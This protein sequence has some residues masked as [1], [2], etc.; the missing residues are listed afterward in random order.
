[1]NLAVTICQR[2]EQKHDHQEEAYGPE[3]LQRLAESGRMPRGK[4]KRRDQY[5]ESRDGDRKEHH[6]T[7]REDHRQLCPRI[8]HIE[9]PAAGDEGVRR[10]SPTSVS[11]TFP[12]MIRYWRSAR[13]RA[14]LLS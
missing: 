8:E 12:S 11:I 14:K 6:D 1:H 4:E 3:R 5:P 9:Q 10:H 2:C 7:E 13:L